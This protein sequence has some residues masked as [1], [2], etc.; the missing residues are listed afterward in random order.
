[1]QIAVDVPVIEH[2]LSVCSFEYE[3][4]AGGPDRQAVERQRLDEI[5]Q[6]RGRES[7]AAG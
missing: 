7:A 6:A 2:G 3:V 1:M 5:G 4:S